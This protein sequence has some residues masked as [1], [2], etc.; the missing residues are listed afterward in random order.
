MALGPTSPRP[1][2]QKSIILP[3]LLTSEDVCSPSM[4]D[5]LGENNAYVVDLCYVLQS[6]AAARSD[7]SL[8][9]FS[10]L[11]SA[12]VHS[13]CS[14]ARSV[15]CSTIYINCDSYE[16]HDVG[17]AGGL[18]SNTWEH[19]SQSEYLPRVAEVRLDGELP[20]GK[21]GISTFL[22]VGQN[23][24]LLLNLLRDTL[25]DLLQTV[26]H[27]PARAYA[28][29]G[30]K[31]YTFTRVDGMD[32]EE[33]TREDCSSLHS[34]FCEADQGILTS[35]VHH[36]TGRGADG[37]GR[38]RVV[39]AVE[40]TDVIVALISLHHLVATTALEGDAPFIGV[41][42]GKQQQRKLFSVGAAVARLTTLHGESFCPVREVTGLRGFF[43]CFTAVKCAEGSVIDFACLLV[44]T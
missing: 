11:L 44:A 24:R 32:A 38:R 16:D 7:G 40:D 27:P 8:K 28:V 4:L 41:H 39:V 10:D 15:S 37:S 12:L 25:P 22:R 14:R 21:G 35:C 26:E 13:I 17:G 20:A 19:R 29:V 18:K 3:A 36:L 9:T 30:R 42:R 5:A 23:K 34:V 43:S 6:V 31:G 1:V 2:A 33:W